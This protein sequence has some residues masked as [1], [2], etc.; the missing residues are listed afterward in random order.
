[1]GDLTTL[2]AG[3]FITLATV[4]GIGLYLGL[5]RGRGTR[6]AGALVLIAGGL[7]GAGA[8]IWFVT[9]VSGLAHNRELREAMAD[10]GVDLNAIVSA[11]SA[12]GLVFGLCAGAAIVGGI[13]F[14]IR[15][16][17]LSAK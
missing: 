3:S 16:G 7:A 17:G 1:M 12:W 14:L 10:R 9:G 13:A 11:S 4:S 15:R 2:I 8:D 5:R 6:V